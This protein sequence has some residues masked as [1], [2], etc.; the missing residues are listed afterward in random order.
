MRGW[1][2]L[3]AVVLAAAC[4]SSRPTG[5]SPA[6]SPTSPTPAL[7]LTS[8]SYQF[9]L[10]LS[11]TGVGT[12]TGQF[13]TSISVCVGTAPTPL[14]PAA[15]P[16]NLERTGDS[17][18]INSA[19]P[20][21]S[22]RMDLRFA[23]G[24]LSGTAAG[25]YQSDGRTVEVDGGSPGVLASVAGTPQSGSVAGNLTGSV[26]IDGYACSNNGHFWTLTPTSVN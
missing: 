21:A 1:A 7:D 15:L 10:T 17:I 14:L 11:T 26:M 6:P 3:V 16:V 13:C 2:V 22:F 18:V 8:G 23:N 20:H 12:C 4:G 19:D 5:P 25:R 24:T 9:T